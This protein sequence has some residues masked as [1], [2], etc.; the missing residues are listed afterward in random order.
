MISSN[1]EIKKEI[2]LYIRYPGE[3]W[4]LFDDSDLS[5][6]HQKKGLEIFVE[7]GKDSLD[8][9]IPDSNGDIFNVTYEKIVS[10]ISDNSKEII[11]YYYINDNME[12]IQM[13]YSFSEYIAYINRLT[14]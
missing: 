3:S 6:Q 9:S 4:K 1:V 2:K 7:S 5:V 12:N 8:I 13:M 11:L 14:T 10:E